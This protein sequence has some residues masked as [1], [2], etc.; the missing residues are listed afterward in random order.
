REGFRAAF[1]GFD[2]D[3]V[4]AMTERDVARLAQDT[5]IIR[6]RGKIESTINN[7][8]RTLEVQEEA[9]SLAAFVWAFEPEGPSP[10][11]ALTPKSVA[12]S[13]ALKQRGFTWTGPTTAYAFMQAMGLVNDHLDGCDIR[14]KVEQARATFQRP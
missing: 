2:I 4:A 13:K 11:A 7:A 6:H 8:V 12:L 10:M 3:R 5:G 14:G 9:G 1:D